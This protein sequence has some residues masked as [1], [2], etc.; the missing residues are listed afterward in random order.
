MDII[1]IEDFSLSFETRAAS[2][3]ALR[4]VSFS[5]P[6]NQ[7]VALVGESG[8]GKTVLAHAILG[9]LPPTARQLS[10]RILFRDP[11]LVKKGMHRPLDLTQLSPQGSQ[12][13]RIRGDRIAMVFQEPMTAFSPVHSIGDQ[14]SEAALLHRTVSPAEARDMAR[15]TLKLVHFPDPDQA[16]QRYPFELSGGL[17]QR[18]MLAMALICHPV[19]LIADEPTTA[20]DV[21]IQAGILKLIKEMQALLSMSVL[22]ITHDFGVVSALADRVV[23]LYHGEV[24]ESG[25]FTEVFGA[26]AH[27]YLKALLHAAPHLQKTSDARLVPLRPIIAHSATGWA[28]ARETSFTTTDKKAFGNAVK[29]RVSPGEVLVDIENIWKRFTPRHRLFFSWKGSLGRPSP[30][31]FWALRGISLQI[32]RGECLGIAGES[33][34]GKTTLALMLL[35][36]LAPDIG[37]VRY[38]LPRP[39]EAPFLRDISELKRQALLAYRRRV[40]LIFQDPFSSLNPRMRIQE[41]LQEPF[42]IHQ[43]GTPEEQA[44]WTRELMGLVGLSS[45]LLQRRPHSFSGGQRQRICIARALAL[46]PELILCDEPVSALDVSVQAQI[47]NLLK[48][49]KEELQLTYLLISHNLAVLSY[50]ADR[51]AVLCRGRIVELGPC[52]AIIEDP[53]HPYT[54]TLLRCVVTPDLE[55]RARFAA[56]AADGPENASDPKSWPAP[57]KLHPEEQGVLLCVAP[58]HF[59]CFSQEGGVSAAPSQQNSFSQQKEEVPDC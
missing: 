50:S 51:I 6:K 16:L 29:E 32:R 14:I 31:S 24:M 46:H 41:I 48:D 9:L 4:Q 36:A 11:P 7:I 17:R 22:L 59:V 5:I 43:I 19:L 10:G 40:Q 37:R 20:L 49:L 2:V 38:K 33:G 26:A 21:T 56:D 53:Q 8:S 25:G 35:R 1:S 39:A 54:K 57:F 3:P 28:H 44:E 42:Q 18:A 30:S 58:D 34:A 13:R 45:R 27:P 55:T 23:V 15:D 52:A 12:M 47:L